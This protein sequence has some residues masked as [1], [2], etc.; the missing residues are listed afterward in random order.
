M[1]IPGTAASRVRVWA[2]AMPFGIVG[3]TRGLSSGWRT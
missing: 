3:P 1:I 2:N